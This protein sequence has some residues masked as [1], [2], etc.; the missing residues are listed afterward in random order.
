M[1]FR[2]ELS[3]A[4]PAGYLGEGLRRELLRRGVRVGG[5]VRIVGW[6]EREETPPDAAWRELGAVNSPPVGELACPLMKPSNNLHAQLFWLQV[7]AETE[8][9]PSDVEAGRSRAATTSDAAQQALVDF[10]AR[11]GIPSTEVNLIEGAGLARADAV[12]PAAFVQDRRA[13]V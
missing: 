2:S 8:N 10:V 11:A 5:Q 13:H 9:Y 7:G 1:L 3:V 4:S 12:T 6:R